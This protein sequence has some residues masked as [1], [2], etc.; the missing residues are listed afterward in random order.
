MPHNPEQCG[1]VEIRRR[2]I[3]EKGLATLYQCGLPLSY[4]VESFSTTVFLANRLPCLSLPDCKSPY[5]ILFGSPPNYNSFRVFGSRCFP[6]LRAYASNKFS[7]RSLS[8]VFLGYNFDH[9][10]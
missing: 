6:Y 1:T 4:W 3:L 9:K 10:G 5:E 2:Y 8:C 7:P